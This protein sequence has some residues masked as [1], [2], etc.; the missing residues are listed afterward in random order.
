MLA[1]IE[2]GNVPQKTACKTEL[3]V[4]RDVLLKEVRM[5]IESPLYT[6]RFI[7]I[8]GTRFGDYAPPHTFDLILMACFVMQGQRVQARVCW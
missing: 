6:G 4:S 8:T 5:A 1:V 2:K 3:L 7:A